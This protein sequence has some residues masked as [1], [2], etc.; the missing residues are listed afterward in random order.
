MNVSRT[1]G[2]S[3]NMSTTKV[4][5]TVGLLM[6]TLAFAVERDA[7]RESRREMREV[8]SEFAQDRINRRKETDRKAKQTRSAWLSREYLKF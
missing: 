2:V 8:R 1:L 7:M 3:H 6:P 5:L 4:F